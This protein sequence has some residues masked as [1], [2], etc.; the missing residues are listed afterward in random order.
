MKINKFKF[1]SITID[2]RMY[3][4]DVLIYP[5]RHIEEREGS[6]GM[7]GSHDIR[8][9]EIEQI[10]KDRP[11]LLIIGTGADGKASLSFDGGH[12]ARIRG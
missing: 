1:G 6:R 4:H 7:F 10:C 5:D 9:E 8:E 3:D 11:D 2:G 12:G